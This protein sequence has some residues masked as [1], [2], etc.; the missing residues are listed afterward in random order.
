MAVTDSC[1][2]EIPD[3]YQILIDD[4]MIPGLRWYSINHKFTDQK[5]LITTIPLDS[6]KN[7]YHELKINKIYWSLKKDSLHLIENWDII[8]FEKGE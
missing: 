1:Q 7:D 2:I 5:G 8:P 3:L 6:V 4:K